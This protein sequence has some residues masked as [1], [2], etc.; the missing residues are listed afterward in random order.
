[1]T[2]GL[3]PQYHSRLE[4]AKLMDMTFDSPHRII[5]VLPILDV[6]RLGQ[7]LR[8]KGRHFKIFSFSLYKHPNQE[9]CRTEDEFS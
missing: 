2:Q 1:M 3:D 8:P 7:I 5:F 4:K 9:L 6:K